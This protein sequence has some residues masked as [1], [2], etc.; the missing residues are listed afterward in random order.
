MTEEIRATCGPRE[1]AAFER[2]AHWLGQLYEVEMPSY[3]D[4]NY[5]SVLDLGRPM[6]TALRL[7]K[8]GAVE[9]PDAQG[10]QL[11]Q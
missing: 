3:I 5:G 1:A 8:S 2:F 10:A 7:L 9:A 11:F 4:R 6:T